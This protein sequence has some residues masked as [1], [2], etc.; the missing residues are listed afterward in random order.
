MLTEE[1]SENLE[2]PIPSHLKTHVESLVSQ[3]HPFSKNFKR[4]FFFVEENV[5]ESFDSNLQAVEELFGIRYTQMEAVLDIQTSQPEAKEVKGHINGTR[6]VKPSKPKN[7]L[8][9]GLLDLPKAKSAK[10]RTSQNTHSGKPQ[11]AGTTTNPFDISSES[12]E[13]DR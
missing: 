5:V 8:D 11:E 3:T 4:H 13:E 9:E 12:G 7:T 1:K 10:P 2:Y 6:G